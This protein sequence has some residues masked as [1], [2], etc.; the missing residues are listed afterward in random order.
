MMNNQVRHRARAWEETPPAV[1][2]HQ[3]VYDLFSD[4]C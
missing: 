1:R 3:W 4:L 2:D